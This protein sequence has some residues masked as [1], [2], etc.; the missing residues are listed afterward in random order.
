MV[1]T[2]NWVDRWG[3]L[4]EDNSDAVDR[5]WDLTV[6]NSSWIAANSE[7]IRNLCLRT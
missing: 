2:S 3:D 7:L 4:V 6:D 5:A 1:D